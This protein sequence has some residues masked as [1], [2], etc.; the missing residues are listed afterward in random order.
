[1][2]REE[3]F[4]KSN[5]NPAANEPDDRILR[6]SGGNAVGITARLRRPARVAG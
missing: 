4:S 5:R 3:T 1:V 6:L 2:L